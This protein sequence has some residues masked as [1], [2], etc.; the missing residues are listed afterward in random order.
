M[1]DK[2]QKAKLE[3]AKYLV[4]IAEFI[5]ESMCISGDVL[6]DSRQPIH[7][8]EGVT[9]GVTFKCTDEKRGTFFI[10]WSKKV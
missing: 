5:K 4:N 9:D 1:T 6:F 8:S 7:T 2:E 3:A 10:T